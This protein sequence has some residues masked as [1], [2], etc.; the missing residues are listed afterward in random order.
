MTDH[1]D[2]VR[3]MYQAF[4]QGDIPAILDRLAPD[5]RWE[6]WPD[7][8][9]QKAGVAWLKPLR[10]REN[11]PQFFQVLGTYKF[12]KFDVK[13]VMGGGNFAAGL[14]SVEVEL[15]WG[16]VFRDEEMHLFEFNDRGQVV[17][18]RHYVD[19]AKAIEVMTAA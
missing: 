3:A 8:Y 4:Q 5:V 7:H 18:M 9:G 1:R 19:T 14:I 16:K 6:D 15:P 13:A 11:V 12:R 2:T 17:M 10:G